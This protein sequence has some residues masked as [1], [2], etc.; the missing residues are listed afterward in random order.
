MPLKPGG[1]RVH[2]TC[3]LKKTNAQKVKELAAST[4]RS[5]GNMLDKIIEEY[6]LKKD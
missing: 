4:H 5:T 1:E 6:E 3:T 2:F